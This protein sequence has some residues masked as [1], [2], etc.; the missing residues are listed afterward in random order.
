ML[1]ITVQLSSGARLLINS[2][3]LQS[4]VFHIR[5]SNEPGNGQC[6][7]CLH[8]WPRPRTSSRLAIE[9]RHLAARQRAAGHAFD[10]QSW[11][12]G[13]LGRCDQ[14][15]D[16]VLLRRLHDWRAGFASHHC[17]GGARTDLRRLCGD[18]IDDRPSPCSVRRS[19][20]LDAA[21]AR[22]RLRICG[23]DPRNGKLAQCPRGSIH[24]RSAFV[25]FRRCLHGFLG[26]RTGAPQHR[27]T[28]RLDL[29][30]ETGE[31]F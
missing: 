26:D 20:S 27:S 31:L 21:S 23:Y 29:P 16:V 13:L 24:T 28:R 30:R 9:R 14:R 8:A 3:A 7:G 19:G 6:E 22:D 25:D 5:L 1:T 10:R 18:R 15:D 11:S 17:V 12:G 2:S 4:I